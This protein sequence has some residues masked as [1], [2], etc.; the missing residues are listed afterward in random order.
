MGG[1]SAVRAQNGNE[2]QHETAG[3]AGQSPWTLAMII[4][5]TIY[6]SVLTSLAGPPGICSTISLDVPSLP[7]MSSARVKRLRRLL[8]IL[9]I[10][11]LNPK[12]LFCQ[13]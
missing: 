6:S 1:L 2:S 12:G 9:F 13:Y 3:K 7:E 4:D 10:H 8:S 5:D 11:L